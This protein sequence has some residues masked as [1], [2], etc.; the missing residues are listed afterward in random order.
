[1]S[2]ELSVK[3]I[4]I[5]P[6]LKKIYRKYSS[7]VIFGAIMVVLL[8]YVGLVLKINKLANAE[9]SIDKQVTVTNSVPHIDSKTVEQIQNL[10]NNN[11]DIHSLFEN[12][13]NNP[14][15]E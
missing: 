6:A 13:R 1:M 15:S 2:K 3:S 5:F 7:H 14:F 8:I 10:E 11:T 4:K 12:A 9:P